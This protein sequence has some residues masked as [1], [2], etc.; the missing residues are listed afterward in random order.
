[1]SRI[2]VII[3]SR[4]SRIFIAGAIKSVLSARHLIVS[5]TCIDDGST[6]GTAEEI[7]ALGLPEDFLRIKRIE[8]GSPSVA[9][10]T[11]L[12][13]LPNE[14]DLILFLDADDLVP[15]QILEHHLRAL[16]ANHEVSASIGLVEY[17]DEQ[18]KAHL[19]PAAGARTQM[20]AVPQLGSILFKRRVFDQIGY[21][22][23]RLVQGEDTDLLFR[24]FEAGLIFEFLDLAA[25]YYRR[26]AHNLTNDLAGKRRGMFQSLKFAGERRKINPALGKIPERFWSRGMK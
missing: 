15:D 9:R 16:D 14:G 8:A 6:D 3:P 26:H 11:G 2:N 20:S 18:D 10:N 21:F 12:T 1:M 22:D 19:R 17:F 24:F 4:N 23:T 13:C 5:I 7:Q 25:L